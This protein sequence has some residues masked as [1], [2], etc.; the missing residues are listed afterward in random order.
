MAKNQ[1]KALRTLPHDFAMLGQSVTVDNLSQIPLNLF[2]SLVVWEE[3]LCLPVTD[4][5]L[6][7]FFGRLEN[8]LFKINLGGDDC[9]GITTNA[10]LLTTIAPT[11]ICGM[12]IVAVG[13]GLN[14]CQSGVLVECPDGPPVATPPVMGAGCDG[15]AIPQGD[16]LGAIMQYGGVTWQFIEAFFRAYSIQI[17]LN[18]ECLLVDLPV[19]EIGMCEIAPSFKGAG[20]SCVSTMPFIRETNQ[21]ARSNGLDCQFLPVNTILTAGPDG[22]PTSICAPPP[23]AAA[24]WGHTMFQGRHPR[25]FRFPKPLIL[26]PAVANLGI[27]F[28]AWG[29]NEAFKNQMRAAVVPGTKALGATECG[30]IGPSACFTNDPCAG[31]G[32]WPGGKVTIGVRL[33]GFRVSYSFCLDLFNRLITERS[34]LA[35]IYAGSTFVAGLVSKM[36]R[37]D[38]RYSNLA[39][40]AG[41]TLA[42]LPGTD[43]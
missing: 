7:A 20:D 9:P 31:A 26:V 33:M 2:P 5:Q 18:D 42:G 34:P 21:H 41:G 36:D 4:A 32:H 37:N 1:R 29:S 12:C 11:I 22:V 35:A 14:F 6:D 43:R 27:E 40:L 39:G 28:S 30:P 25:M 24:T 15:Q 16:Q 10:A 13:E 19:N 38:P 17:L 8:G 23:S 3:T